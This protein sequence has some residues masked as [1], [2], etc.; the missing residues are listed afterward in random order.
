[1]VGKKNHIYM[2]LYVFRS[3]NAPSLSRHRRLDREAAR[4]TRRAQADADTFQWN[5][6]ASS[7]TPTRGGREGGD[8]Y[9]PSPG[10]HPST[11]SGD[12]SNKVFY[13][14]GI[15]SKREEGK[16]G[17]EEKKE[18]NKRGS[19]TKTAGIGDDGYSVSESGD[20]FPM[21][22]G[23]HASGPGP[24]LGGG[25]GS[26]GT[27]TG[28]GAISW[29]R[30]PARASEWHRPDAPRWPG[31]WRLGMPGSR[32]ALGLREE[33]FRGGGLGGVGLGEVGDGRRVSSGGQV[34]T[35]QEVRLDD[36][37]GVG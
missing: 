3:R 31:G 14:E 11:S 12:Y 6:N 25:G 4:L 26:G 28:G 24:S 35:A 9:S 27:G 32:A 36:G 37:V 29:D 8:A 33:G 23:G 17:D 19:R 7:W 20:F 10:Q 5:D 34:D 22:P 18:E 15:P 21:S 2:S 16:E 1:M 13:D 30:E